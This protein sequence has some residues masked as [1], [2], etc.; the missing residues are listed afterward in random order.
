MGKIFASISW[1]FSIL[2]NFRS[3]LQRDHGGRGPWWSWLR[4]DKFPWQVGCCCSYCLRGWWNI[5]KLSQPNL[6][7]RPPWSPCM[8]NYQSAPANLIG[9]HLHSIEFISGPNVLISYDMKYLEQKLNQIS[10]FIDQAQ[11][12]N[13]AKKWENL[14]FYVLFGLFLLRSQK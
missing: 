1:V 5:P 2:V 13:S 7:P 9:P 11:S 12:T 8:S 4:F 6:D 3:V 14:D 10:H